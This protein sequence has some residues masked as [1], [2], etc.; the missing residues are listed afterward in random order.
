MK[1]YN[2]PHIIR[3]ICTFTPYI[4][5]L[6]CLLIIASVHGSVCMFVCLVFV[7][8]ELAVCLNA[9]ISYS[10][11]LIGSKVYMQIQQNNVLISI[12]RK[13]R[14]YKCMIYPVS[15]GIR[16]RLGHPSPL[17]QYTSFAFRFFNIIC[18]DIPMYVYL[19]SCSV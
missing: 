15:Q 3:R 14:L 8:D 12:P 18:V 19:G 5:T 7:C 6:C 4:V 16:E 2:L 13:C 17:V 9:C 11:A 10:F 1:F